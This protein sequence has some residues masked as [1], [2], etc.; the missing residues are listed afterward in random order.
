M[1]TTLEP[2][3]T[4]PVGGGGWFG[5]VGVGRF[6]GGRENRASF[7]LSKAG[8]RRALLEGFVKIPS[9]RRAD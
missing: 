3:S 2:S 8:A 1:P 9:S 4:G 7:S 5:G 6:Q